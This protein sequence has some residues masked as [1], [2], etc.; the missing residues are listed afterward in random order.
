MVNNFAGTRNSLRFLIFLGRNLYRV[1]I[2]TLT[3]M[4][5]KSPRVHFECSLELLFIPQCQWL[6]V[7]SIRRRGDTCGCSEVRAEVLF[8]FMREH[9]IDGVTIYL[10]LTFIL[11]HY[12]YGRG[13]VSFDKLLVD[14]YSLRLP[15]A[16]FFKIRSPLLHSL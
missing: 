8:A 7:N 5:I 16:I 12:G 15:V 6:K 10:T 13:L 1:R 11:T 14:F 3:C 4:F 2:I 9:I